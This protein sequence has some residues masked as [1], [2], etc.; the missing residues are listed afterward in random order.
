M[1]LR[2]PLAAVVW[3][4]WQLSRLEAAQRL[5]LG[6]VSGSV[7]LMLLPFGSPQAFWILIAVHAMFWFSI[8]KLN[9]GRFVDGYKP[10]FPLHL[11][12]TRPISTPAF[13]S[14]AM[15]YDALSCTALYL[16]SAALLNLT[17]GVSLPLFSVAPTL[18]ACHLACTC[19]QWSTRNRIVQWVGSLAVGAPFFWFLTSHITPTLQAQISLV[20][21]A[22][23][24]FIGAVSIGLTIAGVARQRRGDAVASGTPQKELRGAF[25]HWLVTLLK[26]PCPATSATRAQIWFELR[27][28]GLPVLMIGLATAAL[29]FLLFTAGVA[30][31]P[32]RHPAVAIPII[33]LPVILFGLG[34]NA[35][36]MLQ[37]QGRPYV[38]A[39]ELTQPM[40]S[41]RLA[42]I[43]LL[44]RITCVVLALV[45][46]GVSVWGSSAFLG[47]WGQWMA[48]GNK[49]SL[50][51][52][53]KLRG[54]IADAVGGLTGTA[55]LALVVL[56]LTC[57]ACLLAWLAAR[58]ALRV[59]FPRRTLVV[60]W[61]PVAWAFAL[62]LLVVAAEFGIA[63][64]WLPATAFKASFWLSA[65]IM[66]AATIYLLWTGLTSRAL[67]TRYVVALAAALAF[68]VASASVLPG[69]SLAGASWP[70]LLLLMVGVLA[71]WALGRVR[72]V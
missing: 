58:E 16:L 15:I 9:G 44:V 61:L 40:G 50:P 26:I 37:K 17:F 47:A 7:A 6:L 53:L 20:E 70:I 60:Q 8:A 10:G 71:P 14:V 4:N 49:D 35:F 56:A 57:V 19:I 52:L 67:S 32:L 24:I 51:G 13:V 31:V 18:I 25:P 55:A 1:I 54:L 46:I 29:T 30:M 69:F 62:A 43:K 22:V 65:A 28:S 36:G 33:A 68:V 66:A 42:T 72:N 11:L 5:V 63:P 59:R 34:G 39:F 27:S 2:S 21:N 12:Y 3:E 41:A 64:P 45:A 38:S 48:D 23:L